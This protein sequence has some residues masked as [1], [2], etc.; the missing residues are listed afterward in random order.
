[1]KPVIQLALDFVDLK[2]ALKVAGEAGDSVDWVEAGTPLIKSE[3]LDAVRSLRE[4]FPKKTIVA[5]MKIMDAGR[6]EVEAAAKAGAD[7][8]CVLGAACDSTIR[9]CVEAG[10]N[11][12]CKIMVDLINVADPVE[13]AKEAQEFGADYVSI[14]TSIDD[15]MQAK[16]P[17]DKLASVVEAVSIPV[18]AAGGLNSESAVDAV[19]AGASI[20]MVGGAIAKAEDPG[21]AAKKIRAA[22]DK[23]KKSETKLFKRS[24]DVLSVLSKVSTANISDAMH[25]A[26]S[27]DGLYFV[28]H[29][30]CMA[31]PAFTVRTMPGD[32]AKTVEAIDAASPGDVIVVD[33]GGVGPA[34]WGELATE[35]ALQRKLAGVVVNG[36]VR[37]TGEI[38]KLGFP[39]YSRIISPTCG[40]PKGLGEMN[41]PLKI[42]GVS[43]RPGDWIVGDDDGVIVIPKEKAVEI[44]NRAQDVLEKENRLRKEIRDGSSLGKVANLAKWEKK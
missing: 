14:H 8:V 1:M 41:V 30:T 35:S 23:K 36:A 21:K 29:G 33:A 15:Q 43:V 10:A 26:G 17:F 9:E 25:H 39:V 4:A 3:G 40:E 13:R 19:N 11:M 44:A 12:G 2:R 6:V 24:V 20:I 38:A 27:L 22:V 42:S 7:V 28:A 37:D 31:G 34:V 5:D 16:T 18:A 32:W